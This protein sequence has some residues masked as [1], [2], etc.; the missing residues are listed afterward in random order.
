[1]PWQQKTRLGRNRGGSHWLRQRAT[2]S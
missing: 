1:V 2:R